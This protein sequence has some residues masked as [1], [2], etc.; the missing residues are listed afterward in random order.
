VLTLAGQQGDIVSFNFNNASGKIGAAGILSGTAAGTADKVGWVRDAAASAG[1]ALSDIELEI[2]A[3]FTFVTNAAQQTAE[4]FGKMFGLSTEDMLQHPH[5]LFGTTAEIADELI[6]RR[7]L[8]GI[9]YIT[10]NDTAMEAF[11]PV[12][13]QLAGT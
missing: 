6:R 4:G 12:V 10:I 1:R 11:A 2:G 13:E 7:D 9:S 8:Y 3:Y 5:A